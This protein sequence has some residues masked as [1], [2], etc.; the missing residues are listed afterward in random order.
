M[1][2][3]VD[4]IEC[5]GCD[6]ALETWTVTKFGKASRISIARAINNSITS[7]HHL[8][9]VAQTLDAIRSLPSQLS[10]RATQSACEETLD[11]KS[12]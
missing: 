12:F 5:C 6:V 10:N 3:E 9:I 7:R 1:K 4:L 2:N 8:R 11:N